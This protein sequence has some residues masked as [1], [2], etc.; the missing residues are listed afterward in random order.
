M[1][2]RE[3]LL[4]TGSRVKGA[5]CSWWQQK[6]DM[7]GWV[8]SLKEKVKHAKGQEKQMNNNWRRAVEAAAVPYKRWCFL[9]LIQSFTCPPICPEK[10][11]ECELEGDGPGSLCLAAKDFECLGIEFK[12]IQAELLFWASAFLSIK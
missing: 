1:K 6:E 10:S 11:N 4:P 12:L 2:F 8:W 7:G 9:L 3:G 5:N